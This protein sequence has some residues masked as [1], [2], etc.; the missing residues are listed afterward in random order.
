MRILWFCTLA[1]LLRFRGAT[2]ETAQAHPLASEGYAAIAFRVVC[3][4]LAIAMACPVE[5]NG[6]LLQADA[7]GVKQSP[8]RSSS[9]ALQNCF[10][11]V[12]QHVS[13]ILTL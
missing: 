11:W 6:S 7:C 2:E 9:G 1:L 3:L 4:R 10:L 5:F 12:T 13:A 8:E